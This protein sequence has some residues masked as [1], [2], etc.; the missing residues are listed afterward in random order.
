MQTTSTRL[1]QSVS[2]VARQGV[3]SRHCSSSWSL[4]CQHGEIALNPSIS[5]FIVS[6]AFIRTSHSPNVRE[7]PVL[8][9]FMLLSRCWK[10]FLK[11]TQAKPG[12]SD[13]CQPPPRCSLTHTLFPSLAFTT[14]RFMSCIVNRNFTN[15]FPV[16][17]AFLWLFTSSLM[18]TSH[19]ESTLNVLS[20][21]SGT[22]FKIFA[23]I[24]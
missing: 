16:K 6:A 20:L 18:N 12:D 13:T 3:H 10:N 21:L 1:Y 5:F 14:R 2:T 15:R 24:F 8:V 19:S 4:G 9:G 11:S 7:M 23:S 22:D 17:N